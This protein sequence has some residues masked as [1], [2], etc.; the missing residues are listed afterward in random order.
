[1]GAPRASVI[2]V[3]RK[4]VHVWGLKLGTCAGRAAGGAAAAGGA[5]G[6][7]RGGVP[8]A[9]VI[10]SRQT[11]ACP[12]TMQDGQLEAP[13]PLEALVALNAAVFLAWLALPRRWMARHFEVAAGALP[14]R[15]WTAA[16]ATVS[17]AN[18][19]DLTGN[20]QARRAGAAHVQSELVGCRWHA[21]PFSSHASFLA[22]ATGFS[23]ADL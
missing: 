18:L 8:G 12:R 21:A 6:A 19:F 15:P 5:G 10:S 23:Y 20:M 22:G 4:G 13:P 1:M 7:Q 14:R 11:H 3:T 16:A 17:H 9:A 2:S